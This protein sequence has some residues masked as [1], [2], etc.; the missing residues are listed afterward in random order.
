[1][2]SRINK[3]VPVYGK[4]VS[5][6]KVEF[7]ILDLYKM[8]Q[9]AFELYQ[10]NQKASDFNGDFKGENSTLNNAFELLNSL[11]ENTVGETN[12]HWDFLTAEEGAE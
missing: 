2:A 1:M 5:G 7:S 3:I 11:F 8:R 12:E 9:L 6:Y 4:G 10:I